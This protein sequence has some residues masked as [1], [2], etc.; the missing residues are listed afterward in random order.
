MK[1]FTASA[2]ESHEIGIIGIPFYRHGNWGIF[3]Y[4][5][6]VVFYHLLWSTVCLLGCLFHIWIPYYKLCEGRVFPFWGAGELAWQ[7][8]APRR[9]NKDSLDGWI[10]YR[11]LSLVHSLTACQQWSW[12]W[13]PDQWVQVQQHLSAGWVLFPSQTFSSVR[14]VPGLPWKGTQALEWDPPEFK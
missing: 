12:D 4:S 3:L 11:R 2:R 13:N 10:R 8:P 5:S 7:C 9:Y 14:Q 6:F 1:Y